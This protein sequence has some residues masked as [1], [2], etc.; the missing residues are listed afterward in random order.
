PAVYYPYPRWYYPPVRSG[1]VFSVGIGIGGFFGG[2]WH[3]WGGWGWHP[4]WGSHTVVVNN[5]FIQRNNFN[6]V[7]TRNVTNMPGTSV[8]SHDAFHRQ[9]VPYPNQV[10]NQ[11]FGGNMQRNRMPSRAAMPMQAPPRAF[12]PESHPAPTAGAPSAPARQAFAGRPIP[13]N[14]P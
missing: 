11:G 1:L 9:G 7:R 6:S 13:E 12:G 2:G 3:G 5:T 10:L 4:A 14:R 8:W